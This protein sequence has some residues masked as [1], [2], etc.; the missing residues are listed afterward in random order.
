MTKNTITLIYRVLKLY[1][2][3]ERYFD[4]AKILDTKPKKGVFTKRDFGGQA[5]K[6]V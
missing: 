2:C 4:R 6:G 5:K 3:I 1:R